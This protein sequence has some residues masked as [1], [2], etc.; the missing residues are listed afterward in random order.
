MAIVRLRRPLLQAAED[1]IAGRRP[2]GTDPDIGYANL[3]AT[4][5]VIPS[6]AD[7]KEH[8]AAA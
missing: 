4:A 6:Q 7:R 2:L 8:F 3:Y 1:F 5:G